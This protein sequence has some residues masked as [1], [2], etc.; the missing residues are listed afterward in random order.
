MRKCDMRWFVGRVA[1][2]A[3]VLSSVSLGCIPSS[4]MSACAIVA[5]PGED[6]RA[7]VIEVAVCRWIASRRLVS[8]VWPW[9]V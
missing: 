1:R 2:R 5:S 3:K 7:P 6:R 8:I 9:P 4:V